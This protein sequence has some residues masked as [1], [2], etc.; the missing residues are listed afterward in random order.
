VL[1]PPNPDGYFTHLPRVCQE[2]LFAL[3]RTSSQASRVRDGHN[4]SSI[5][6]NYLT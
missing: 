3:G 5:D 2:S 4:S 6:F 1:A